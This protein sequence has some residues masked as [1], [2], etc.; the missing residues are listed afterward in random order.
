MS[1]QSTCLVSALARSLTT[2]KRTIGVVSKLEKREIFLVLPKNVLQIINDCR[3]VT[4]I[5]NNS[6]SWNAGTSFLV[7]S[8]ARV[9]TIFSGIRA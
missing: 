5:H 1:A 3:L 9:E 2:H 8:S 7:S 6:W 4:D